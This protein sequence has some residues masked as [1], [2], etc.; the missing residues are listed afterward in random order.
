[1]ART[2]GSQSTGLVSWRFKSS[3]TS[4]GLAPGLIACAVA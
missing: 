4:L 3:T 1:M 2:D